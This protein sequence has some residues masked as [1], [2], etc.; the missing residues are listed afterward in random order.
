MG[1]EGLQAAATLDAGS[2]KRKDDRSVL[3]RSFMWMKYLGLML[4]QSERETSCRVQ[5]ACMC[6]AGVSFGE[7]L[8]K[9]ME[10]SRSLQLSLKYVSRENRRV[11]TRK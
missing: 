7:R 2:S 3:P 4:I 1:M 9:G 6:L 8:G 10:S 11:G 5:A